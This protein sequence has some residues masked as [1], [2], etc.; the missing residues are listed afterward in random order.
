MMRV[1]VANEPRAYREVTAE[2]LGQLRPDVEFELT[3]PAGLVDAVFR[4]APDMVVCDHAIPEVRDLVGVWLELYPGGGSSS[5][6]SVRGEQSIIDDVQLTD[7]IALV[8]R[9]TE[10]K[11]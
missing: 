4:L 2:V 10:D 3:D 11:T 7:I 6:A 1:V 5:V 8:D 9:V